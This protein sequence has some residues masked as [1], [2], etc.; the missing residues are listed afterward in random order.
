MPLSATPTAPRFEH[1]TDPSDVLGIGTPTPRLSWSVPSA[2]AG[3]EQTACEVEVTRGGETQTHRVEGAEQVLVPW[4][5]PPLASRE[6]A[7]VRVRVAHKEEWSQWSEPA[8]VE[9]GLLATDDWRGVF[10]SPVGLGALHMPAPVLRGSLDVT[11]E[12]V[13]ARLY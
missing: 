10:V 4:P 13:K 3:Y 5:A 2:D 9:A 8:V 12:V 7:T 11:G 6:S 1:R